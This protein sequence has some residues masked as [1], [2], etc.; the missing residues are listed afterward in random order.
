MKWKNEF[1]GNFFKEK[2]SRKT[3]IRRLLAGAGNLGSSENSTC[4]R[5]KRTDIPRACVRKELRFYFPVP[6]RNGDS[7]S[8]RR[9]WTEILL[10]S[11]QKELRFHFPASKKNWDSTCPRPKRTS[12]PLARLQKDHHI[13]TTVFQHSNKIIKGFLIFW[14]SHWVNSQNWLNLLVDDPQFG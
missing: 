3:P 10:A 12:I 13:S 6:K 8:L 1:I 2:P 11:S 5:P 9:N 14:L 4:L 7:T